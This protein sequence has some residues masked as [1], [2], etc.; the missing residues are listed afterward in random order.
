[1]NRRKIEKSQQHTELALRIMELDYE[2]TTADVKSAYRKKALQHHPDKG[3]DAKDFIVLK[4]AY[5]YLVEYGT[6][7]VMQIE[8][9]MV[10]RA[11]YSWSVQS[12]AGTC[13]VK[14]TFI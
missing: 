8:Q 3:G 13:T 4:Q 5:D 7:K 10:I 1:M 12:T 11:G 9:M 2:A 14:V 6:K